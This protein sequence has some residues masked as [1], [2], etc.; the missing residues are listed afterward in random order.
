[1]H[2]VPKNCIFIVLDVLKTG[3]ESCGVLILDSVYINLFFHPNI[4][5]IFVYPMFMVLFFDLNITINES[6][7]NSVS[8]R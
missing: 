5:F 7:P 8:A 1:M 4:A 2:M 3:L 6:P